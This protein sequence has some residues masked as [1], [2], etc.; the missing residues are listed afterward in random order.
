MPAIFTAD[1]WFFANPTNPLILAN[2]LVAL[3]ARFQAFE[4]SRVNILA[5]A[6]QTSEKSYLLVL[7]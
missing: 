3:F 1:F 2:R 6:K 5:P 7:G 4:A